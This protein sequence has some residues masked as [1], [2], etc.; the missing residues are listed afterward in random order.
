M[1]LCRDALPWIFVP[2]VATLPNFTSPASPATRNTCTNTSRK[3]SRCSLR[4]SLMVRKSGR[5]CPT[6][7]MNARLRSHACEILRLEN[8]PTQDAY[9][10]RHTIIAGSKGGGATGCVLIGRIATAQ[11]QLGHWIEQEEHQ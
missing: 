10:N 2:S 11:V 4:K 6:M 3:A 9:S 1:A 8:T 5:S 7:A